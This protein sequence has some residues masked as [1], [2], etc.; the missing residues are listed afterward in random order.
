MSFRI[1]PYRAWH[2]E[3][4]LAGS[5]QPAQRRLISHVPVG[6]ARV[7]KLPG[8]ALSALEGDH[9]LMTGGIMPMGDH[10][11]VLWAVLAG[12]AGRYMVRLHRGTERF[13]SIHPWR[14]LEA[15]VEEGFPA[16][17]RWLELLGFAY[18]GP[19]R[20]YGEA[21]E[22]HIRYARVRPAP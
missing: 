8:L 9:V 1:E 17:C 7:L 3:A 15:S 10:F 16:G 11:G 5:I 20:A 21:G 19:L 12:D 22:D 18:E 2:L 4:V 13:L 6:F 14:R